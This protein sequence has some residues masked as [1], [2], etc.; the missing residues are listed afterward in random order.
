[1]L[2]RLSQWKQQDYAAKLAKTPDE[3]SAWLVPL[4]EAG[5]DVFQCSQ[6]RFWEAEFEGSD[7]NFAGW[8][9]KLTGAVTV[10]V[11]SVSL[12]GEFLAAFGGETSTPTGIDELV[13]RL[14]REDF[15]LV[16]IGRALLSNP[17]WPQKVKSGD[18]ED[19]KGFEVSSLGQLV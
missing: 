12:S 15:D 9:K 4:R 7:L 10:S 13:R 1:V 16:A 14:E 5:V 6:R 2:L 3:M 8:A 19:L 11:G 17:D 18:S